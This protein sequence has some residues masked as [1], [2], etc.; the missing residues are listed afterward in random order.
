MGS[1]Y[2]HGLS[3]DERALLQKK[4]WESQGGK[5]F[6]SGKP[7]DLA[8]DEV[9]IDHIIPTRT[10]GR[11]TRRTLPSR[12]LI[13][14]ARNRRPTSESRE[15]SRGLKQS[16]LTQTSDDRGANLNDVLKAYGGAKEALRAKIEGDMVTYVIGGTDKVTVPLYVDKLS[17]MRYFFAVLPIQV[18]FHDERIN[19]RPLGANLRGFGRRSSQGPTSAP[20]RFGMDAFGSNA[21]R[22]GERL[23]R[24]AQSRSADPTRRS[25]VAVRIFVDPNFDVLLTTNTNAGTTLRQVAFDKAVQRRLGSSMLRDRIERYR[26]DKGLPPDFEDFSERDIV[27]YFKGEQKSITRY[28]LDGV[29]NAITYSSDNKL[30]DY[31]ETAGKGS[32]KPFFV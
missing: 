32:E 3:K 25:D 15:C 29:R 22:Q 5:C 14:I 11:T 24:P 4:L 6:I 17:G 13:T 30:R 26:M 28:V 10:M 7:I 2:L 27:D 16:R 31:I 21:R 20:C 19:P 1:L 9:D 23:R 8:L 18:I 12:S